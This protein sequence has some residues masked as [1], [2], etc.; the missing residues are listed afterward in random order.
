ME[1]ASKYHVRLIV[2][3][4]LQFYLS[5]NSLLEGA[6]SEVLPSLVIFQDGMVMAM[7]IDLLINI[8][9]NIIL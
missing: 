2:I 8:K 6:L 1:I 3:I 9:I 7:D 4:N 5:K